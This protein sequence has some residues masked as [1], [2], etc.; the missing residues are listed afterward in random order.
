LESRTIPPEKLALRRPRLI[1]CNALLT[2]GII[3]LLFLGVPSFIPFIVGAGIALF[4]NYGRE[5]ER[6]Q[7]ARIKAHAAD[8]LP[9][10]FTI[11]CAGIFLGVLSGT[12]MIDAMS[13]AIVSVIP[14]FFGR[15]LHIIMGILA[16]PISLVFEADTLN[17]GVLPVLTHVGAEYG[18][19]PAEA[20]LALTIGHN[21][22]I[23]LCMTSAS[24]YFG[25]GLYGLQYGETFRYGFWRLFVIG[26]ILIIFAALVGAI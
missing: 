12:K 13:E 17:Y 25:L 18:I 11:L 23:S 9:M 4:I 3:V 8:I 2:A 6:E 21:F 24:V 26:V 16:I 15:F 7:T 14:V 10:V 19:E 20:A 1:W 5:G 22:G